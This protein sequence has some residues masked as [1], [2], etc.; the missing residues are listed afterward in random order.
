IRADPVRY[1]GLM[2]KKL[3]FTFD[4]ESFPVEYLHEADPDRW[5]EPRRRSS[6]ELLSGFHR[7]LLTIAAFAVVSRKPPS[8]AGYIAQASGF[9]VIVAVVAYGWS[10][11]KNPFYLLA[12]AIG[13]LGLAPL[14]GAP[15]R[16]PALLWAILA[17]VGTLVTHAV[18]FGEDRYHI[19][20]TP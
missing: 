2:P 18:F 7:I 15:P 6:R 1:V 10:S 14:P 3:G 20:V 19:V 13:V 12:I 8:N 16:G 17:V 4:H 5:P 9:A 11:D